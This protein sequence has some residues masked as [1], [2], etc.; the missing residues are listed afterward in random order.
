MLAKEY[1]SR[2]D[3]LNE[4]IVSI[5]QRL[6]HG[7][8]CTL[9]ELASQF[10]VSERTIRKDIKALNTFLEKRGMGQLRFGSHGL[11]VLPDDFKEVER[12]IPV[13][14]TFVYKMS[15]S[16]R[17]QLAAAILVAATDYMTLGEIAKL[18]SVSRATILND[19]DGIKE[20]ILTAGLE[21]ESKPSRGVLVTGTESNRRIFLADF[22]SK[23]VPVVDQWYSLT[24]R[25][26]MRAQS[27]VIRKILNERCHAEGFTLPDGPFKKTLGLLSICVQR[28]K[29]GN[30][31]ESFGGGEFR[32]YTHDDVGS[33]ER[34]VIELIGQYCSVS[35]G[36]DEE[37][38]FTER[39]KTMRLNRFNQFDADDL[40]VKK[41][42]RLFTKGVS[43]KMGIDLNADYDL[44]EFLSNHLES[45][46]TSE[47]SHFPE[48]PALDEVLDDQPEVLNAVRDNLDQI[49]GYAGRPISPIE[50]K[51][52][53]LHIC[54]ALERRRNN[55]SYLPRVIVV[56]NGG[57]GTSQLLAEELRGHF[58]IKIVKVMPSH[59]VPYIELYSADLVISTVPLDAC[60]VEHLVIHLP[61]KDREYGI[62]HKKLD[63]L[64]SRSH[65]AVADEPTI[66][67][68]GLLKRLEP[69]VAQTEGENGALMDSIRVEVRRY[70]HEAQHIE[71]QLLSPYLHQLLL[72][73]YIMLDVDC[74]DWKDAI[75]K[76]SRV[77]LD[78][79]YIE[80]RYVSAMI[81]S[82]E[83]YG[84]YDV[85]AP[86]FAVP[87]ASPDEGVVKMGM[88]LIRL[89][90]PVDFA[91]NPEMPVT[92]ICVL[93]AVDA[94]THLRAFANL[95]DMISLP[96]NAFL[97]ALDK[98]K[99]S[100]E[101]AR[102]IESYEYQ[103]V[104]R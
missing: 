99:T 36:E 34:T 31:L 91:D 25:A 19:L 32:G 96:D 14:D 78:L 72:P 33:Y 60:P 85:L 3:C 55:A 95:L 65:R 52:L 20:I 57:V 100:R 92:F 28:N 77:L 103:L 90:H 97:D 67:A 37:L 43:Q 46:F 84:P 39:I 82:V 44:F 59:E 74:L 49:E 86:G 24:D 30:R 62:I 54:A 89:T 35:M 7:S 69:I 81:S 94:K 102:L 83:R 5:V 12:C 75:R 17:K 13:E 70:F 71:S 23:D 51:Y 68:S 79:G 42:A 80:E 61:L 93:S 88:S 48:N 6:S 63:S 21:L 41:L 47:P 2:G 64:A 26:E 38:F 11:I 56:C 10:L 1:Y 87:H 16:E 29:E 4:R 9:S 40:R 27:I 18:F 73:S 53:A 76:A 104:S 15:S 50:V 101:A 66:N 45:M 22:L 58:D 8:S 98:A